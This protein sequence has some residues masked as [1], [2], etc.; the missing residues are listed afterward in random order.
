[1]SKYYMMPEVKLLSY[2][3]DPERVVATAARTCYSRNDPDEVWDNLQT[4]EDVK[5]AISILPASHL[6]PF[7]HV[8]FTFSIDNV[9]RALLAQL[10][11]HRIASYSVKSQR[12]VDTGRL[13]SA[14]TPGS[15]TTNTE[16]LQEYKHAMANALEAYNRIQSIL[17]NDKFYVFCVE[18]ED[19]II[20]IYKLLNEDD[21]AE[22][23]FNRALT[24]NLLVDI[25]HVNE[26]KN[27]G[28]TDTPWN[29]DLATV[30]K[31]YNKV[32]RTVGEDARYVLP[33]ATK[34]SLVMTMNARELIHFFR[35]RCC[36]RAQEEIRIL[37]WKMLKLV[38]DVAPDLFRDRV[39][40]A[41]LTE[42]RCSE[43]NM[44][45]GDP[46]TDI[47]NYDVSLDYHYKKVIERKLNDGEV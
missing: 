5:K 21:M 46:Y 36:K 34:T 31:W 11:R 38:M 39:G 20:R 47:I 22:P 42:G 24:D 19:L 43:G 8:S 3:Q 7:E 25:L 1:M 12:Y 30:M 37:A 45:C 18:H 32:R 44:T 29:D 33:N 16:A 4:D 26:L 10:T 13:F 23:V 2:T 27:S 35:E 15:I 28:V 9:S 6:S 41:C 40:P 17:M 14:Y